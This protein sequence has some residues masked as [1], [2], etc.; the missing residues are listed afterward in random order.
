MA[1]YLTFSSLLTIVP[2]LILLWFAAVA[3]YRLTLHPLA[4][5][6]GPKR[7]AVSTLYE[8]WHNAVRRGRYFLIWEQMHEDYG[9][10]VRINPNE[11]HI[12]DPDYFDVLF[13]HNMKIDKDPFVYTLAFSNAP[14]A[15][16]TMSAPHHRV[17]RN[18]MNKFFS[19]KAIDGYEPYVQATFDKMIERLDTY[20]KTGEVVRMTAAFKAF[21]MDVVSH[22]TLGHSRNYLDEPDLGHRFQFAQLATTSLMHWNRVSMRLV[23]IFKR[24]PMWMT[25]ILTEA[26]DAVFQDTHGALDPRKLT[27]TETRLM[28]DA[29]NIAKTANKVASS[30]PVDL[31]DSDFPSETSGHVSLIEF[32]HASSLPPAERTAD[33]LINEAHSMLGAGVDTLSNIFIQFVYEMLSAP[34]SRF[35]EPLFT[36]LREAEAKLSSPSDLIPARTAEKLPYLNACVRESMRLIPAVHSRLPRVNPHETMTYPA[37]PPTAADSKGEKQQ[38][39]YRFPPG[40][41]MSM[42]LTDLAFDAEAFGPDARSFRPERWLPEAG[43]AAPGSPQWARMERCFVPFSRGAR[44]CISHE[45]AKREL[46]IVCANL[47]RRLPGLELFETTRSDVE[48]AFELFGPV[49]WEGSRGLRVKVRDVE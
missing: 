24:L 29:L 48:P 37:T 2:A 45:L 35:L 36:E 5:I 47:F 26:P 18:A 34:R 41:I 7:A 20:R 42:S 38:R 15:F 46:Y 31:K 1:T 49:P 44:S 16:A 21:A 30:A 4:V 32:L 28:T 39:A 6:P 40:T 25:P 22:F 27:D 12:R 8:K 33:R 13:S 14:S 23:G 10:V 11:V 17:R 3:V 19:S 43:G 9:P